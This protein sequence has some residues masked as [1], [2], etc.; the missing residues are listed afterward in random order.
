LTAIR[1]AWKTRVAG[2][3]RRRMRGF[4]GATRSTSAAS[5][6]AVATGAVRRAWTIARAIRLALGY[7]P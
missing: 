3:V 5:S 1:S 2:W 7:S 6:S 4:G